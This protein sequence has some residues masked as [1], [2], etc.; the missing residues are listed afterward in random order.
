M[1]IA[2]A[3]EVLKRLAVAKE[4]VYDVET[5]GLDWRKCH[6]VGHVLSFG[7]A[8]Q[9]SLY[10]PFRHQPGGNIEGVSVPQDKEGW[11]GTIHPIEVE[12]MK[13]L[14]RPDLRVVFHNG[15]FDMKFAYRLGMKFEAKYRDTIIDAAL[16]NEY[17]SSFSL[18]ACTKAY[19]V[20]A[21]KTTIYDYL[22]SKF[23]E[24]KAT[25]K[26]AMGHFW[27]L[28]GDD[29][30]A[31]EYAE[32]D[33]TSTWLL[34]EAMQQEIDKQELNKVHDV[35]CRLL[36][37]LARMTTRGIKV[38]EERLHEIK[39][40]VEQRREAAL[41]ALPEEF[42]S[43]APTQVRALMERDGFTD[44]PLTPKGAPSFPEKWLET[45]PTGKLILA[46]RKYSNLLSSFIE[47][48]IETHLWKGRVHSEYNQLRGD[49]F[50]TISGRLSSSNPNNQQISKR[51]KELGL[52][53]RSIFVPDTGKIW[54]SVDFSQMEPRLLAWYSRSK[55]L[56]EGYHAT[57]PL[58]AHAAV[59]KAAGIDRET[60]KRVNQTIITGGGKKVLTERYGVPPNKA[61]EIWEHFFR[62][63]PEI[64]QL[65]NRASSTMQSRGYVMTVLGRR[66][67]LKDRNKA[68]VAVNR[69]LQGSNADCIKLKMCELDEYLRSEG[70]PVELLASV[71]DALDFQ[72]SEG[73][74][75]HYEYCLKTM[76][77]F[78]PDDVI[79][80]DVPFTI[81]AKEGASWAEATYT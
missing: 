20:A 55:V 77:S 64:R 8:P 34:R 57:P 33:G 23:P 69:L 54:G 51:N 3:E 49:D 81:D 27:R 36:P 22:I 80:F 52:L 74:R 79:S 40:I 31:V 17:Q 1:T 4:V 9:D 66:V 7:A 73:N 41:R 26:Q 6:S 50:G 61:D 13:L 11:D 38:N 78:G 72:F 68:Y 63:M 12:L 5:S 35:E 71:H 53:Y 14:D 59:A 56:M 28:A 32:Q 58:D 15:S 37:V 46:V 21:K 29:P 43:R 60:G 16:I 76:T 30:Q 48:M 45:N 44:W 70:E 19:G 2:K 47:P 75:K 10:I 65:H 25:P 24:L 18:D 39:G 62:V 42:N 67:R